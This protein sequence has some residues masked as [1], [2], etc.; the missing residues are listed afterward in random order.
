MSQTPVVTYFL[1]D[2]SMDNSTCDSSSVINFSHFCLVS[3]PENYPDNCFP[4]D[5]IFQGFRCGS[6]HFFTMINT[7]KNID[8]V[9]N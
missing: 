1:P 9:K 5:E 6:A 7:D 4:S 2:Y 3:N 8:M